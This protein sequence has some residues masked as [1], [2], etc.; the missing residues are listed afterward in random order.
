[1]CDAIDVLGDGDTVRDA[2]RAYID[3]GV[4]VPVL[5]PLPWGGDRRQVLTDTMEAA[6]S[7]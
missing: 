2:V 1:M 6:A 3:A 4:D 7:A 5:M